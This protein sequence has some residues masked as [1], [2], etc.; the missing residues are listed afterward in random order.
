MKYRITIIKIMKKKDLIALPSFL[1]ILSPTIDVVVLLKKFY[2][3][4]YACLPHA[5]EG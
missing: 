2:S 4:R 3:L 1:F 5:L